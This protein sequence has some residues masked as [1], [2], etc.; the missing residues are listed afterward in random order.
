[1]NLLSIRE[2]ARLLQVDPRTLKA[3]I[4]A[5]H[6]PAIRLGGRYKISSAALW[7]WATGG[8]P[9]AGFELELN[10]GPLPTSQ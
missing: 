7:H 10:Q 3:A 4:A 6:C 1:L 9:V 8:T 2:A 5:G